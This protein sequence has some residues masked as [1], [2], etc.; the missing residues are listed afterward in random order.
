MGR[1]KD[2]EYFR[3]WIIAGAS[4]L[5]AEANIV[6]QNKVKKSW[7][8]C[9]AIRSGMRERL[10]KADLFS[11]TGI[12]LGK[13][14]Y[15]NIE[16]HRAMPV[17]DSIAKGILWHHFDKLKHKFPFGLNPLILHNPALDGDWIQILLSISVPVE[18]IPRV[19]SY[20]FGQFTLEGGDLFHVFLIFY[21]KELFYLQ[22]LV[23]KT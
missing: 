2:D 19:F 10:T 20:R 1:S 23:E 13:V 11:P 6:Y 18:L 16:E 14:T 9:P 21:D 8:R 3:N 4:G 12:Y 22:Y 7:L 15:V 5:N 17:L